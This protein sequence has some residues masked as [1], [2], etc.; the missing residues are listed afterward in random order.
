MLALGRAMGKIRSVSVEEKLLLSQ[1]VMD[2][3]TN[4]TIDFFRM[5]L[6]TMKENE[7]I[8]S[9]A[10]LSNIA[11]MTRRGC[12]KHLYIL[13][14]KGYVERVS[15]S[16]WMLIEPLLRDSDLRTCSRLHDIYEK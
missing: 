7:G 16:E 14:K 1:M 9:L 11:C 6:A 15:H 13:R 5:I 8:L 3:L 2:G 4:S 12:H 10:N